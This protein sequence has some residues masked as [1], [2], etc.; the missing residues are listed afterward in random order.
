[1]RALPWMLALLPF[2]VVHAQ[3][4][5]IAVDLYNKKVHIE[6]GA[7]MKRPV[8]GL[9]EIATALVVLDWSE[10]TKVSLN[11]LATVSPASIQAGGANPLGFQPGDQITL[12]DL[13][14]VC[15]MTSDACAA[16]A[17][18]EFVGNDIFM[19]RSKR[20]NPF[21]EFVSQMNKLAEREGCTHTRFTNAHGLDLG[22]GQTYSSAADMARLTLY[23]LSRAPFR[24]Y[25]NQKTR[26]IGIIRGGQRN[27]QQLRNTN[28]LLG[29][30]TIDGVKTGNS[31][32]SGG[33]VVI[34][35]ERQGTVSKGVDGRSTV[36]RHRMVVVVLGSAD[37]FG[38]AQGAL[39][40]GWNA[41][42]QWLQSGR[43]VT[44]RKQLLPYF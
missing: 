39:R 19:R 24:F 25:T 36:F 30:G 34:T 4:S 10:T 13:I 12:R 6:S 38:Q 15:M 9:A 3:E 32:Q 17:L 23:A 21:V 41:Y 1:M 43:P 31:P 2:G 20:G 35:E 22:S 5:V 42:D 18:A 11:V 14:Y 37:P 44:D 26:E 29:V 8:G 27:S 7:N 40:A 16:N 33:C 28:L